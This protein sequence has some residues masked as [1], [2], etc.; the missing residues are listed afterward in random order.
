MFLVILI[1]HDPDL[2]DAVLEAW[3]KLGVEGATVIHSTGLG[4]LYQKQALRDDLPLLPSLDDFFDEPQAQ[5]LSRTIITAIKDETLIEKLLNAAQHII[6]DLNE[7]DT[8]LMIVTP[9]VK[10]YGLDKKRRT[11]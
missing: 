11:T 2:L 10:A 1:L 8:G 7:P 5:A 3:V 4:R 6:G 9:L